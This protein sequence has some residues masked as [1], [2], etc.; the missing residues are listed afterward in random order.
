M[1]I[2]IFT[3]IS[4][5][6]LRRSQCT[7]VTL[8]NRGNVI[9]LRIVRDVVYVTRYHCIL[10]MG[11]GRYNSIMRINDVFGAGAGDDVGW[12]TMSRMYI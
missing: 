9:G 12:T 7:Y 5:V 11:G 1:D 4:N 6:Y 10:Q 2:G 3:I 8:G